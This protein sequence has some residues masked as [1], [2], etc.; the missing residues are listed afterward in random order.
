MTDHEGNTYK[1]KQIGNL[2][3]TTEN[4]RARTFINGDEIVM[5]HT[6]KD[7]KYTTK[8]QTPA[9][10][11]DIKDFMQQ[12]KDPEF[13]TGKYGYLYNGFVV[14]DA[15]KLILPNG[16]RIPTIDDFKDLWDS[17]NSSGFDAIAKLT[18]E[19]SMRKI[20]SSNALGF[21][22]FPRGCRNEEGTFGAKDDAL[23]WTQTIQKHW[24]GLER[25]RCSGLSDFAVEFAK[26]DGKKFP[27]PFGAMKNIRFVK[28]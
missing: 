6:A 25:L 11:L 14:K 2:T 3:W 5:A 1:T 22:G 13:V 21:N 24:D 27:I 4:F 10:S 26:Y 23:Y 20:S 15:E 18:S 19:N 28:C 9:M 12:Q 7:V 16:W 17:T 8:N